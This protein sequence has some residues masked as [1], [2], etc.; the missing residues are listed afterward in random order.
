MNETVRVYDVPSQTLVNIPACELAPGMFRARLHGVEGDVFVDSRQIQLG[1]PFRYPPF[2]PAVLEVLRHIQ[3]TFGEVQPRT[4]AD[5]ENGFRRDTNPDEEVRLW[6]F[7]AE[8]YRRWTRGR[9]LSF[10]RKFEL[11]L[12][13]LH[14]VNNGPEAVPATVPATVPV[15]TLDRR[16]VKALVANLRALDAR[17]LSAQSLDMLATVREFVGPLKPQVLE[18]LRDEGLLP[19]R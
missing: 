17:G 5:W 13:V 12:V 19:G 3:V 8:V 2:P 9:R 16:R 1:G 14:Y 11:Y 7:M 10:V 18:A 4:L 15:R 6:L